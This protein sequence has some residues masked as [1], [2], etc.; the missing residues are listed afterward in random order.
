MTEEATQEVEQ[1]GRKEIRRKTRDMQ[2]MPRSKTR[3][4]LGHAKAVVHEKV[5]TRAA[6][7]AN[8]DLVGTEVRNGNEK[9]GIYLRSRPIDGVGHKE[10][11]N[12]VRRMPTVRVIAWTGQGEK[13]MDKGV[14]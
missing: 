7:H 14:G 13:W 10:M 6:G 3:L 1:P 4:S 8:L 12:G 5:E 11:L 9:N 2:G